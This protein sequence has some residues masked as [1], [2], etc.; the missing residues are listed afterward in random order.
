MAKPIAFARENS[1]SRRLRRTVK[2]KSDRQMI[3]TE[4]RYR[5]LSR[6]FCC[7]TRLKTA[8]LTAKCRERTRNIVRGFANRRTNRD[9][10]INIGSLI[11]TF[12]HNN[13][14]GY[15]LPLDLSTFASSRVTKVNKANRVFP[16]KGI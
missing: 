3:F 16:Q 9:V 15:E 8:T 14:V 7:R 2:L 13:S 1:L 6:V 10:N 11:D 5:V 12:Q 4:S